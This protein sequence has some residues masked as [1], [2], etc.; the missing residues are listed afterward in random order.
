[1]RLRGRL[2]YEQEKAIT[3][4]RAENLDSG[5]IAGHLGIDAE[6]VTRALKLRRA[7]GYL[8]LVGIFGFFAAIIATPHFNRERLEGALISDPGQIAARLAGEWEGFWLSRGHKR[9][10]T[11]TFRPLHDGGWA[12]SSVASDE[13]CPGKGLYAGTARVS[14]TGAQVELSARHPD[15]GS[16]SI[17][18]VMAEDENGRLQMKGRFLRMPTGDAGDHFV[19]RRRASGK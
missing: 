2:S 1:M 13:L 4:L 12:V 19:T 16:L 17:S 18:Y 6:A 10:L 15:C 14:G 8:G 3:R 7:F 5:A 11:L 9:P